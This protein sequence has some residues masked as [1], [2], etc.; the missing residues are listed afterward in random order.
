MDEPPVQGGE[1]T[2]TPIERDAAAL[3]GDE[4]DAVAMLPDARELPGAVTPGGAQAG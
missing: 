3:T 1:A 2:G 4:H